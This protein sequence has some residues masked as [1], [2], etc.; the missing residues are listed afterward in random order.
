[1]AGS[2]WVR[3]STHSP[4]PV[5][6]HSDWCRVTADGAVAGCM[7]VEAGAFRSKEGRDGSRVFLHRLAG[8]SRPEGDP[9][10]R[11][12]PEA[13]RAAPGTLNEVYGALLGRLTLSKPH[14]DAL[15]RR[16]LPEDAIER[17]GYRTLPVQGRPRIARDLRE[18]FG[19]GLLRVPG[20]V[21]KEGR[22]GRY[23]TLRGPAGLVVP[24]RD[25]S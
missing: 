13:K 5:C 23:L 19:D 15:S 2:P 20:F 6:K 14:R 11:P 22:S 10:P 18:R 3:V 7:R 21:V 9:P 1:M 8:S 16:G 24:C 17:G 12:G 25:Q 4:C